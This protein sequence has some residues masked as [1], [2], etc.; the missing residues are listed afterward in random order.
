[1]VINFLMQS[2]D[3]ISGV[4]HNTIAKGFLKSPTSHIAKCY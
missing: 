4:Q 1:M 3:D 2:E